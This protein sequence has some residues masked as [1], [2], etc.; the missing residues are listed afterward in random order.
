MR[1]R[2]TI[3]LL[4]LMAL[5]AAGCA[6]IEPPDGTGGGGTETTSAPDTTRAPDTT[7]AADTTESPDTTDSPDTTE[8]PDTTAASGGDADDGGGI[9]ASTIWIIVGLVIAF[10]ILGWLMGRGRRPS[11]PAATASTPPLP[12]WRDHLRS[13]YEDARWLNDGMTEELGIWRGN[14]LVVGAPAAGTELADRWSQLDARLNRARD[15]LYRA[16]AAAPDQATAQKIKDAVDRLNDARAS[17]DARAE[18]RL[19]ASR[20]DGDPQAAER[21]RV[22]STN[23]AEARAALAAT[24]TSVSGLL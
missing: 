5:L 21:E 9:E 4:A 16:E 18:A 17:V 23:L 20:A 15:H 8:S 6:G 13:G 22:A 24:L 14:S 7:Q 11:P 12:T 10:I 2:L 1:T 19:N 3:A